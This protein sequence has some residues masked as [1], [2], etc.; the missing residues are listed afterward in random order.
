MEFTLITDKKELQV[1][2]IIRFHF[3]LVTVLQ[4]KPW[5]DGSAFK[6]TGSLTS[7]VMLC[8]YLLCTPYQGQV[9]NQEDVLH[10][11]KQ[12]EHA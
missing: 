7:C 10:E 1:K 12:I 8:K 3:P 6:I 2:R 5:K 9:Y 11:L 4:S